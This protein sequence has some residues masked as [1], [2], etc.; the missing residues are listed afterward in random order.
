M[1]IRK[2]LRFPDDK[3]LLRRKSFEVSRGDDIK[4]IVKDLK[5]TLAAN[6]GAGLAAPQIGIFK[7]VVMIRFGQDEGEMKPPIAF[8]NPK[9]TEVG[10]LSTGF[11]GCLSIPGLVT[12]DT[13]RPSWLVVT[14]LNENWKKI[15]I[16]VEGIDARLVHHE[17]DHLE[18]ILFLD[19]VQKGDQLYITRETDD[20]ETLE[21]LSIYSSI[22]SDSRK[23]KLG[24][25]E[26][27]SE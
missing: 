22:S 2:I 17:V 8:I 11:D 6:P 13:L 7:R 3:E 26:I 25:P 1:A 16:R 20:G 23:N 21:K 19:R 18:G 15:K 5:D 12:W 27:L 4:G 9:I 10:E 24:F 14:A